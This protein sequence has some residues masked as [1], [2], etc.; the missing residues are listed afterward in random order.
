LGCPNYSIGKRAGVHAPVF[1][2]RYPRH[3]ILCYT[4]RHLRFWSDFVNNNPATRFDEDNIDLDKIKR[5]MSTLSQVK[6]RN[7]RLRLLLSLA[8]AALFVIS[9]V[10]FLFLFSVAS[11]IIALF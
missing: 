11:E 8:R 6:Q 7:R 5:S 3:P 10:I 9:L 1:L 2:L 4:A